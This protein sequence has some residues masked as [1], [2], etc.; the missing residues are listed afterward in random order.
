[1]VLGLHV[2]ASQTRWLCE[3]IPAYM[4]C[5]VQA[6]YGSSCQYGDT[7]SLLHDLIATKIH[8]ILEDGLEGADG[9][10]DDVGGIEAWQSLLIKLEDK[11]EHS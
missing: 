4:L 8:N 3:A 11:L 2:R 6:V 10:L 1:M 9:I 5:A 7:T